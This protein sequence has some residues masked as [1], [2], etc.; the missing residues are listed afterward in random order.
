MSFGFDVGAGGLFFVAFFVLAILFWGGLLALI[1]LG[2]RWL[3]RQSANDRRD[4]PPAEDT[5]LALLRQRYARGE[6]DAAEF[7][8]RKRT[9]GG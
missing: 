3:L 7:E 8:E 2:I 6:I 5:A 4:L 1:L 9:L